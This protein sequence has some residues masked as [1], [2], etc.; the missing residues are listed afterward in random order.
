MSDTKWHSGPPPSVDW[1]PASMFRDAKVLRWWNGEAWSVPA[2]KSESPAQAAKSASEVTDF[3]DSILW[4]HR[5][6]S[7][8][9]RSRT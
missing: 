8:P 6:A 5:P 2:E 9:A 3:T 4:Q 7:W 1:W